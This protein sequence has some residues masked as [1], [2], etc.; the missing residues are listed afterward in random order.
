MYLRTSGNVVKIDWSMEKM[1]IV[2]A[3]KRSCCLCNGETQQEESDNK[4]EYEEL[5]GVVRKQT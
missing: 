1:V 4:M 2:A 5:T 3:F